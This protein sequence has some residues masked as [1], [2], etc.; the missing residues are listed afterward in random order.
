LIVRLDHGGGV[1]TVYGELAS[2]AVS[3]GQIVG[4]GQ[5]VGAVG[6][7]VGVELDVGPHLHFE[8]IDGE[9]TLDPK[10]FWK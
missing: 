4:K 5:Q 9:E 8:L 3:V 1:S 2:A 10:E 7:P 6:V